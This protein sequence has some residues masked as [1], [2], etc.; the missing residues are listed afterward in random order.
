MAYVPTV[1]AEDV[2]IT[3][4]RLNNLEGQYDEAAA[5]AVAVRASDAAELRVEVVATI[6]GETPTAGRLVYATDVKLLYGG[7]GTAWK[8]LGSDKQYLYRLGVKEVAWE[9]L[10]LDKTPSFADTPFFLQVYAGRSAREEGAWVTTDPVDLTGYNTLYIAW[11]NKSGSGAD[12]LVA[13]VVSTTKS[14][15]LN[16]YDARIYHAGA[17]PDDNVVESLDISGLSGSYYIR[18]HGKDDDPTNVDDAVPCMYA[19]WLE[20]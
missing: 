5:Y 2:A 19:L 16:T 11:N 18:M 7:N 20:V 14:A 3:A 13:L 17:T 10:T 1:W 8:L 9:T 6:T 15:T 12:S 4:A